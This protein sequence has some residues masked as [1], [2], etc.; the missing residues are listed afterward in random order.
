MAALVVVCFSFFLL[1]ICVCAFHFYHVMILKPQRMREKLGKQGIKGPQPSFFYGNLLELKGLQLKEEKAEKK[2]EEIISHNHLH[3][4]YPAI[5]IWTK[6]YGKIFTYS[7]GKTVVLS[8]AHP[9]LLK[10]INTHTGL[11]LGK[12]EQ[13][14]KVWKAL[15]GDSLVW[16][17]GSTWQNQRKVIQPTLSPEKVKGMV[18]LIVESTLPLLRSWEDRIQS[19]G[20]AADIKIDEDLENLFSDVISRACFGST[21]A[22]GEVIFLKLKEL[23][24]LISSRGF[25]TGVPGW[26]YLPTKRNRRIWGLEKEIESLIMNVVEERIKRPTPVNDFLQSILDAASVY[27]TEMKSISRFIVDNCKTMYLAGHA[28]SM[29]ASRWTLYL[30]AT[31]QDWQARCRAEVLEVCGDRYPDANSINRLKMLTLVINESLRLYSPPIHVVREAVQDME[32]SGIFLPKGVTM[33][34]PVS[35]V[36]HDHDI[37]GSDA[38]EFKPER[39][40]NG[41]MAASKFPHAFLPFGLGPRVCVGQHLAMAELKVVLSLFLSKF[42]FTISPKY[43]HSPMARYWMMVPEHGMNILMKTMLAGPGHIYIKGDEETF[44]KEQGRRKKGVDQEKKEESVLHA[45]GVRAMDQHIKNILIS[46]VSGSTYIK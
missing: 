8:V 21:Y 41:V 6:K 14:R 30:L 9:Q 38:N 35:M 7:L 24:G 25:T 2:E 15:F 44:K 12:P 31:Y 37:W 46:V 19:E 4:T 36:H 26:S 42:S 11:E 10:A 3:A 39:F 29:V 45:E 27:H 43:Q 1:L 28:T 16:T 33:L 34:I 22:Q 32:L 18:D 17:N 40:A 23:H 13:E 5:Q 20:G